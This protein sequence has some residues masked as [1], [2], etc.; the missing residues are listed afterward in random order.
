[1]QVAF[2]R[3]LV[4]KR[5]IAVLEKAP[6]NANGEIN[7]PLCLNPYERPRQMVEPTYGREAHTLYKLLN[8]NSDGTARVAFYPKTGRTHQLRLHAAHIEGL[9]APIVGDE[10]YGHAAD[11]L[12]LHAEALRFTHPSTGA[13]ITIE[14]PCPF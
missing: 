5:Y 2:S 11:R 12:Y 14:A 4:R 10:L 6:S 7:L 8:V 3:G 9:N 1:M 13:L